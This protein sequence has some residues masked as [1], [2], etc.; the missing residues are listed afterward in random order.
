MEQGGRYGQRGLLM[1]RVQ[2]RG[3]WKLTGIAREKDGDGW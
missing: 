2:D 1:E 3:S